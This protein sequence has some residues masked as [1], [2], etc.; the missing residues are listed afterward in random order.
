MTDTHR[1]IK[2]AANI[3]QR[4]KA[5]REKKDE[6][7]AQTD[8]ELWQQCRGD[9]GRFSLFYDDDLMIE[10]K[11]VQELV[12][13][14]QTLERLIFDMRSTKDELGD[15]SPV[16]FLDFGGMFS[17]S[18]LRIAH[19][20]RIRALIESSRVAIVVSNIH[21]ISPHDSLEHR[22][23]KNTYSWR[24]ETFSDKEAEFMRNAFRYVHYINADAAE[25]GKKRIYLPD[26]T[27]VFLHNHL[28]IVHE[29][30]SLRHSIKT[31]VDLPLIYRELDPDGIFFLGSNITD[32][33][34]DQRSDIHD[35]GKQNLIRMGA[36]QLEFE[37]PH[38]Y[39]IYYKGRNPQIDQSI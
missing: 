9:Y 29:S 3:G 8:P 17:L 16:I 37:K 19:S 4:A 15:P 7:R 35:T 27:E 18:S 6:I 1:E 38:R 30:E 2:T 10:R 20:E 12:G 5:A 24:G 23:H 39:E 31:D 34:I 26:G 14:E 13:F 28:D 25:L 22:L 33:D 36:H 32:I 11:E 21:M